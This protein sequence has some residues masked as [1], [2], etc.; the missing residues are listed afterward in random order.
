VIRLAVVAAV[1]Y[2][3]FFYPDINGPVL[4]IIS[5]AASSAMET[6]ILGRHFHSRAKAPGPLFPAHSGNV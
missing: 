6:L 2:I 3:S 4:G 5:L 1:G